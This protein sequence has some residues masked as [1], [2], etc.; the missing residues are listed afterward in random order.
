ME[1]GYIDNNRNIYDQT[2]SH[3]NKIEICWTEITFQSHWL[4]FCQILYTK[5]KKNLKVP[6]EGF[7][8]S[9]YSLSQLCFFFLKPGKSQEECVAPAAKGEAL[10]LIDL[11]TKW[12]PLWWLSYWK[13]KFSVRA[14]RYPVRLEL[15]GPQWDRCGREYKVNLITHTNSSLKKARAR[16]CQ[17]LW[18]TRNS[19]SSFLEGATGHKESFQICG[20]Y[21]SGWCFFSFSDLKM[22][23]FSQVCFD[24]LPRAW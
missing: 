22:N 19:S 8:P 1:H 13:V 7:F 23:K 21:F 20:V 15:A 9:N 14:Q 16:L 12:P 10:P 2:R 3:F 11:P 18:K 24:C 4:R 17:I 6:L 5:F